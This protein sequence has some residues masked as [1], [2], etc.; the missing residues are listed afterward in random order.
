MS[1]FSASHIVNE[2]FDG[3]QIFIPFKVS[4][5]FIFI[6]VFEILISV[7]GYWNH[8]NMYLLK[9]SPLGHSFSRILVGHHFWGDSQEGSSETNYSVPC[10]IAEIMSN[11]QHLPLPPHFR[12]SPISW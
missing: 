12:N 5:I 6:K 8:Q 4:C 2:Q 10:W 3:S 1:G 11:T 7:L 9:F